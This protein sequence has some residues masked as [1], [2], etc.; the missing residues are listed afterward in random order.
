MISQL[1][2]FC[3]TGIKRKETW[4]H[5]DDLSSVFSLSIIITIGLIRADTYHTRKPFTGKK[6]F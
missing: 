3:Y 6:P 1:F 4:L 2:F 5:Q